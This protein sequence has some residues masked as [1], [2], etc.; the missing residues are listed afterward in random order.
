[1]EVTIEERL[2]ALFDSA[3]GGV[4]VPRTVYRRLQF[5]ARIMREAPTAEGAEVRLLWFDTD[6]KAMARAVDKAEI[7]IGRDASC[8]LVLSSPRVSRRHCVVRRVGGGKAELEIDELG[9][10]NGTMVNGVRLAERARRLV[11]DGDV[12]EVAGLAIGVCGA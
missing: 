6:G 9:S 5:L 8:D 12:I 2:A 3:S 7:V 10:S 1:M 11:G 4:A